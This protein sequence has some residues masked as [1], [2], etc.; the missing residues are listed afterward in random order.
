MPRKILLMAGLT[1]FSAVFGYAQPASQ[2]TGTAPSNGQ[3]GGP[4]LTTP[5]ASFPTPAP[6][7]GIS[8]AGRAG[9]SSQTNSAITGDAAWGP[10]GAT[11]VGTEPSNIS[12]AGSAEKNPA[13]DLGP[14]IFVGDG[15][16]VAA[17]GGSSVAEISGRYKAEKTTRNLPVLS[18][19]DVQRILNNK[20][21]VTVTRNMLPL[22]PENLEQNGQSRSADVQ[23][24]STRGV[25]QPVPQNTRSSAST[26]QQGQ[27][28]LVSQAE[29]SPPAP[30]SQNQLAAEAGTSA[31]NATT[32]Q[33]NRHQQ[34]NDAQ[35]RR[36]LP[37]TATFLPL[38]GL[39]GLA[40]GA[41]GLWF[42]KFLK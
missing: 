17:S 18:N 6:T 19:E 15:S 28:D 37:A 13:N 5:T 3:F 20:G 21:G 40:S 25:A 7:A 32:P 38:L 27:N 24:G 4:I 11:T 34:T 10:A 22:G 39:L 23:A 30:A 42:R 16:E 9:I 31:D 12:P 14:S 36:R 2:P 41:I 1:V 35:G 33:I 26:N 8:D 29:T